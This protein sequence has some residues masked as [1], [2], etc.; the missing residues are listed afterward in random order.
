[1]TYWKNSH[2]ISHTHLQF[3]TANSISQ[4]RKRV[5]LAYAIS[6]TEKNEKPA[7]NNIKIIAE[8][9]VN[10]NIVV[11][12]NISSKLKNSSSAIGYYYTNRC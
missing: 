7:E 2:H 1:M 9:L 8:I 5:C 3:A 6:R 10:M 4:N 11:R 12:N